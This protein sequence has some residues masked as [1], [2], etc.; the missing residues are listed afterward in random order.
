MTW[1]TCKALGLSTVALLVVLS[2]AGCGD[3]PEQ[4]VA[5]AQ[6]YIDRQDFN[7]AIIQLK[8]ALTAQPDYAEA[9]YLLGV[10][11]L[12]VNDLLSAEKE[13]RKAQQLRYPAEKTSP[14][15]A[16]VLLNLG[17]AS[18]VVSEFQG[19]TLTDPRAQARLQGHVG[20]AFLALNKPSEASDFF[21]K[22]L[23]IGAG[24]CRRAR[25]AGQTS[26]RQR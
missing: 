15:L 4:L 2:L 23:S 10:S 22:A 6:Q 16:E 17:K 7:S 8:N 25:W 20:N 19:T 14:A 18:E 26:R 24:Q 3:K 21:A 12:R 5:S 1:P 13:L 9:R 11:Q